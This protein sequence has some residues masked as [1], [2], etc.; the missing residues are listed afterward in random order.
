MRVRA[1]LGINGYVVVV[2]GRAAGASFETDPEATSL[3]LPPSFPPLCSWVT[4]RCEWASLMPR[5]GSI[6]NR[7]LLFEA[8]YIGFVIKLGGADDR[9]GEYLSANCANRGL[10]QLAQNNVPNQVTSI[11]FT[12]PKNNI[13]KSILSCIMHLSMGTGG[14]TILRECASMAAPSIVWFFV[15]WRHRDPSR[16]SSSL[17]LVELYPRVGRMEGRRKRRWREFPQGQGPP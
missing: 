1:L 6:F 8:G 15:V 2:E 16:I 4:M 14:L 12:I 10:H 9:F 7:N 11:T 13:S 3:S 17:S 5:L